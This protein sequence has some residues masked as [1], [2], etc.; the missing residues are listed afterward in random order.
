MKRTFDGKFKISHYQVGHLSFFYEHL[1]KIVSISCPKEDDYLRT[2]TDNIATNI[3]DEGQAISKI[4]DY[5]RNLADDVS[6]FIL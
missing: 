5:L 3:A 1:S 4:Q 6:K 2:T